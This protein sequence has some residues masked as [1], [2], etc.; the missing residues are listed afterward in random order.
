MAGL[1]ARTVDV[2]APL[3]LCLPYE[4]DAEPLGPDEI[5]VPLNAFQIGIKR[6]GNEALP[7]SVNNRIKWK[8]HKDFLVKRLIKNMLTKQM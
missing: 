6:V 8:I 3:N 4:S 1:G 2:G 5:Y 7:I